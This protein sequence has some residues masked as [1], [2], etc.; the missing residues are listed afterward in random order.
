MIERATQRSI[1]SNFPDSREIKFHCRKCRKSMGMT[2]MISGDMDSPVLP[3]VIMKCHICKKV[4]TLKK[5]T[6]G[7]VVGQVD[8]ESRYYL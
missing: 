2:Y 1:G 7:M 4:S 6:E 3:N 5:Y 8:N